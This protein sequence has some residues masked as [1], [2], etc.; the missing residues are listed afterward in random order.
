MG[1]PFDAQSSCTSMDWPKAQAT[2]TVHVNRASFL[3]VKAAVDSI[4]QKRW[5]IHWLFL[6]GVRAAKG[7]GF[8]AGEILG[9][10]ILT[11]TDR[12]HAPWSATG[13][14]S[15]SQTPSF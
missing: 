12:V 8:W 11:C 10:C 9:V 2:H 14:V 3:Q 5:T 6:C 4:K 7:S 1:I 13:P 15:R